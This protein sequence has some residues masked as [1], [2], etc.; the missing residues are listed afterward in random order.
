MLKPQK[1]KIT[2]KR[3]L[4]TVVLC[5]WVKIRRVE[6]RFEFK[7]ADLWVG[8]YVHNKVECLEIWLCL[9]PCLQTLARESPPA[10]AVG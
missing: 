10:L 4:A 9:L 5:P 7:I 8:A 3:L 6:A 1:R 2:L